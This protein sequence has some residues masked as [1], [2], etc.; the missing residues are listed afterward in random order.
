MNKFTDTV[1]YKDYF[2]S[3]NYEFIF[4]GATMEIL[5]EGKI[6]EV[7]Q[8]TQSFTNFEYGG[9]GIVYSS[10]GYPSYAV[11]Q[12]FQFRGAHS[13]YSGG[14]WHNGKC[15]VLFVDGHVTAAQEPGDGK[16]LANIAWGYDKAGNVQMWK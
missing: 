11:V 10:S 8:P 12:V 14:H 5:V 4:S 1:E 16:D 6:N 2:F 7:K 13:Y 9:Q 3:E 15:N